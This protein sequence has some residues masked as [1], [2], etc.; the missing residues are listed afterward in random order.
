MEWRLGG[1]D[2][3]TAKDDS[4][5]VLWSLGGI[6]PGGVGERCAPEVQKGGWVALRG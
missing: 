1:F 6:A 3:I 4:A 5:G 2:L